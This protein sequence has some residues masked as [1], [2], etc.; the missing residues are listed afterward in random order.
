LRRVVAEPPAAF[1]FFDK[2]PLV[3]WPDAFD[4]LRRH[5]ARIT[6]WIAANYVEATAFGSIHVWLRH[7][8]VAQRP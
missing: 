4:D 1:V 8:R 2:A 5:D 3:S 6:E 7:D